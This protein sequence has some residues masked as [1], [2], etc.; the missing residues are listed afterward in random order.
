[1]SGVLERDKKRR[2][3]VAKYEIKRRAL[4]TIINSQ[5]SSLPNKLVYTCQQKLAELPRNS[6]KTRVKNRCVITNRSKSVH[7]FFK[8]SRIMLRELASMGKLPG[9]KKASW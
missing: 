5:S 6:S 2:Q 4:K 8:L 9:V 1:M 7:R 3:L